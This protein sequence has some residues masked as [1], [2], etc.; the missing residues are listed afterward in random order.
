[1]QSC[2]PRRSSSTGYCNEAPADRPTSVP[3]GTMAA[4]TTDEISKQ[5][6][7]LGGKVVKAD[8]A[9][10]CCRNA[11]SRVQMDIL[12]AMNQVIA[13][14]AA[15]DDTLDLAFVP[16][17]AAPALGLQGQFVGV[18][19]AATAA[20]TLAAGTI[21]LLTGI[22]A[23]SWSKTLGALEALDFV[24]KAVGTAFS[25]RK[26][27]CYECL[28]RNVLPQDSRRKRESVRYPKRQ[29]T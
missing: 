12:R 14:I 19:A 20:G 3:R 1:M 16:F 21:V 4:E 9:L 5:L 22:Q 11:E 28:K 6:E 25:E 8:R 7:E 2:A 29:K 26:S 24:N 10:R 27:S 15:A 17:A 23:A 18:S 13:F